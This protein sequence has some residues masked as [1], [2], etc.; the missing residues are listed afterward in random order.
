MSRHCGWRRKAKAFTLIE[1]LVVIAIIAVLIGLLLPAVQKV[2]EAAARISSTNNLKQ[3]G[4][5]IHGYHD[6]IGHLPPAW[7]DWDADW[8]PQWYN[9]CGSTHYFILPY[10]EQD[11][12]AKVGPPYYFWQVYANPAHGIN[13]FLNPSDPSS[14]SDGVYHDFEFG[15][16]GVTGYVANFQ[17]LGHFFND[18]TVTGFNDHRIMR[19]ADVTDG[20]SNT[21]FMA[22]K[23][24]LCQ[25]PNYVNVENSDDQNYYSIWA[26]GRTAWPE[27]DPVFGY[28]VTG[29]ASKFQVNPTLTGPAA[30]C[31]PRFA[32]SPRSAGIL[33]AMGDGSVRLLAAGVSPETWWALCT[34]DKREVIGADAQ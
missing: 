26:Y 18:G 17:S 25:N 6:A 13:T 20:L 16:Y 33:V 11:A 24:T 19:I 23:V 32:S 9:Q 21:I 31:D 7:V 10:V 15:D 22:E 30:T 5:A 28:M 3:I 4:L 34:P 27:W 8:N 29:P 12:L 1:L 14:P 2:R